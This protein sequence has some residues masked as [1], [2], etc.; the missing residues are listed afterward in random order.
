MGERP[1]KIVAAEVRVPCG[2]EHL[3]DAV[4]QVE[5]RH[6]EC[7]ATK[8]I[9]RE[10]AGGALVE[11]VGDR[12]CGGLVEEAQHFKSGEARGVFGGLTLGVVEVGG[13]GDHRAAGLAEHALDGAGA[14]RLQ[15]LAG[16]LDRGDRR[17]AFTEKTYEAGLAVIH[18]VA[19]ERGVDRAVG[20][21]AAHEPL[22]G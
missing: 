9:H 7:A 16:D 5:D 8:V 18:R 19:K 14:Q 13:H 1:V 11:T 21:R 10:L 15:D 17:V 12:R 6:V 22:G 4:V 3:E 20:R 2:G